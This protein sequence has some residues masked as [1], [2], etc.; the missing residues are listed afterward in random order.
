[1]HW[2][3]CGQSEMADTA[4]AGGLLRGARGRRLQAGGRRIS[5]T[6]CTDGRREAVGKEAQAD[7]PSAPATSHGNWVEIMATVTV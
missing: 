5:E 2:N 1:M 4:V 6:R 7:T 3:R